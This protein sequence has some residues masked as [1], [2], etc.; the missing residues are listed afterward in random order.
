[1]RTG[2]GLTPRV[3]AQDDPDTTPDEALR[4]ALRTLAARTS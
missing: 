4:I 2:G 3:K 1:V